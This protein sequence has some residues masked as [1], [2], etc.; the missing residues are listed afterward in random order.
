MV[1]IIFIHVLQSTHA[2]RRHINY[3]DL[4]NTFY[5]FLKLKYD[6]FFQSYIFIKIKQIHSYFFFFFIY[7]TTKLFERNYFCYSR[8]CNLFSTHPKYEYSFFVQFNQNLNQRLLCKYLI[9]RKSV[10]LLPSFIL[11]H[12]CIA[13]K[14]III[15]FEIWYI[16]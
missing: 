10:S 9:Y 13:Y 7:L 8:W 11:I 3:F 4:F 6:K 1:K 2:I 5:V 14:I 16:K 15:D 12:L